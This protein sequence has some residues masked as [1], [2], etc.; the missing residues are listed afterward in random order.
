[1]IDLKDI[2]VL[3]N[4]TIAS[5]QIKSIKTPYRDLKRTNLHILIYGKV[6][7]T[8]SSILYKVAEILKGDVM[9]GLTKANLLGTVDKNTK[10]VIA[11]TIWDCRHN[12][13]FIDEYYLNHRDAIGRELLNELLS[14]MENPFYTKKISYSSQGFDKKDKGLYCKIKDKNIT[15]KTKF[16][17]FLNTMM[18]IN[19]TQIHEFKALKTRCLCVPMYFDRK[20]LQK[21][22]HGMNL[23]KYEK[24]KTKRIN[25]TV[26]D[27]IY[28][29]IE[30]MVYNSK[31]DDESYLRKIEDLCRIYAVLGK[32]D[33]DI[34]NLVLSL[35]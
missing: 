27:K 9:K 31:V 4:L 23:Y 13:L 14:I 26:S 2:S 18:N 11:P 1:M 17:L 3:I 28:S 34:F 30:D 19:S 12:F 35:Y 32:I 25:C 21:I 29:Q 33:E 8:K 24:L 22:A 7:S 16:G 10:E 15:I 6:G 20:I 5:L